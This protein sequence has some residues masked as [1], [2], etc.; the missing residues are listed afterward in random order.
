LRSTMIQL[1][2]IKILWKYSSRASFYRTSAN[3]NLDVEI[4]QSPVNYVMGLKKNEH[5]VS[6]GTD[7]KCNTLISIHINCLKPY[8]C[9]IHFK[10]WFLHDITYHDE[11][12]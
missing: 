12:C 2:D 1:S 5:S 8:Q 11:L 9:G 4:F 6:K 10:Y 3:S 7:I